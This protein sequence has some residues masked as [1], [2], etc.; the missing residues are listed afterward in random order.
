MTESNTTQTSLKEYNIAASK[1]IKDTVTANQLKKGVAYFDLDIWRDQKV[2][3]EMTIEFACRKKELVKGLYTCKHCGGDQVYTQ[4]IQ[5]RSG[6][7]AT[8]VFALCA[9]S[10][11]TGTRKPWK[12]G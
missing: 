6:D 9:N 1:L 5:T 10:E 12:V 4:P 11:C 7:E 8:D 2:D 3:E